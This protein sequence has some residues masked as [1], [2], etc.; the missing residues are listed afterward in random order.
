MGRTDRERGGFT[1]P[2]FHAER[3]LKR[4]PQACHDGV[5]ESYDFSEAQA[6]SV[7]TSVIPILIVMMLIF[8][9][10]NKKEQ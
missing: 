2:F 1:G 5:S 6:L 3:N 9:Y 7:A 8:S 10:F 4:S